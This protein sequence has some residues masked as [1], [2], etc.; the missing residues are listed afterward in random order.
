[1][2]SP[3]I[4]ATLAAR[5]PLV[6]AVIL[7]PLAVN[8]YMPLAVHQQWNA[9]VLDGTR[10][11]NGMPGFR[12]PAGFPIVTRKMSQE[13][14]DAIHAYVLDLSWNA[15]TAEQSKLNTNKGKK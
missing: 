15:Y 9:I 2:L 13:E 10:R 11:R 8:R 5:G 3:V 12:E 4:V 14:A 6:L 7:G 1:M